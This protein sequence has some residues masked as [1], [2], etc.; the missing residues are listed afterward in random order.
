MSFIQAVEGL[1]AEVQLLR[2]EN[3][4]LVDKVAELIAANDALR[5]CNVVLENSCKGLMDDL[6]TKETQ[7][8]QREESLK[9]EVQ[10]FSYTSLHSDFRFS[11]NLIGKSDLLG[12]K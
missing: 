4:K 7:W 1:A 10:H 2:Y 6:S 8:T 11:S 3:S 9:H 5:A 12:R